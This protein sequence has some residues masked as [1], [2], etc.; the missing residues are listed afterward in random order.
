MYHDEK[1]PS[2]E[3]R[4]KRRDVW[5]SLLVLIIL[6]VIL[7]RICGLFPLLPDTHTSMGCVE[8]HIKLHDVLPGA[9]R[10]NFKGHGRQKW[11]LLIDHRTEVRWVKRRFTCETLWNPPAAVRKTSMSVRAS[12]PSAPLLLARL[13]SSSGEARA[14]TAPKARVTSR[15]PGQ[16]CATPPAGRAGEL[17]PSDIQQWK[18]DTKSSSNKV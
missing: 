2:S 6:A 15:P 11:G 1:Y 8:I 16:C 12:P 7:L 14:H 5:S 3:Y 17:H 18:K 10:V 9:C 4:S 13:L